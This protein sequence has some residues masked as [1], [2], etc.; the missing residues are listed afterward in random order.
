MKLFIAFLVIC[1]SAATLFTGNNIKKQ[2]WI[3][4][5]T[6]LFVTIGYFFFRQI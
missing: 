1:F 2:A 4:F 6:T 3:L 5:G